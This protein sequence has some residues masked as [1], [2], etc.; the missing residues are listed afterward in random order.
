MVSIFVNAFIFLLFQ[1]TFSLETTSNTCKLPSSSFGYIVTQS[2]NN[3][4]G[5]KIDKENEDEEMEKEDLADTGA[6]GLSFIHRASYTFQLLIIV[7]ILRYEGNENRL[8][9][10]K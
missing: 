9:F 8:T 6:E 5:G 4:G 10:P 1:G 3:R 7:A 2:V